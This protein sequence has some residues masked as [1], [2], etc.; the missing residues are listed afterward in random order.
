MNL[1]RVPLAARRT[2]R[3]AFVLSAVLIVSLG[4]GASS[5]P[6][7]SPGPGWAIR[8]VALPSS[9]STADGEAC[10]KEHMLCNSNSYLVTATNIGTKPSAGTVVVNDILPPGFVV[11]QVERARDIEA[12]ENLSCTET[13]EETS[14]QCTDPNPVAPGDTLAITIDVLVR[15]SATSVVNHAEV[16]G[17]E[18]A[19]AAT[20]ESTTVN[21]KAPSFGLQDFAVGVYGAGGAS[22]AQAGDHPGAL[23]TTIDYTTDFDAEGASFRF[24]AAQE[25]K[26]EIVDLPLGFV[27]DP[28]AAEQ[29]PESD[30]RSNHCPPDSQ[31]G[32]ADIDEEG[33][34][35][36][37]NIYNIVPEAGYPAEFAFE[38]DGAEVFLHARV[39][40][41]SSGYVLSISAP[42]VPRSSG[43]KVTGA[44]LTFFGDPAEQDGGSRSPQALYTNPSDCQAGPL[45]ARVEMDSW[46]DPQRWVTREATMYEASP[47]QGVS[48]CDMLQ[49]NPTIELK[50]E[51]TQADTP[52][53]Y[54]V[55]LKVPQTPNAWPAH[56][57]PDLRNTEVTLPEGV[58]VSPSAADGLVGCK[59]SGPEGIELGNN[60][61]LGHEVQEGEEPGADGLPHAAAGHC[62]KASQIGTV[63]VT[64]PLL[65]E[66]LEG[67]VYV[68]Q[69]K[70]G[71]EGQPACT[72]ASAAN[73]ELFGLYLE[74]AGSGVI[75]KLKG[76]VSV[77]PA[78]G[79]IT[80]RFDENPQLPFSELKLELNG[81]PRAPLANPQ[82]CGEARTTS[83]L[84]PWS[85]PESGPAATPFT[86]FDVSGC[87]SP[88]PFSPS[89]SAGTLTP[90]AGAFS[91][92]TLTFSR[93]DGQQDLSGLTVQTPPGLLGMLSQVQ[94]CPEPQA[95]QGTCGP[96]SQIGHTEVAAGAGSHPFWNPGAVYLTGPYKGQPFGLSIVTPATAGPF[97]LGNVIVRAAIH[98]DPETSALT[99]TSDP[100]PQIIDGVQLRI[101]T[102]NVSI[103]KPGFMFNPTN[104]DQQQIAGLIAGALP[105]GSPGSST[106]VSSLFA[107]AGCKNLP[108]KP[109]FSASTQG[110]TSK[111]DGASLVVK[112][113][114]KPGEANIH[115]VDLQLPLALP[116]RLTT[117]QK[118]CSEAQFASNPAG[119]PAGSVI[120]TATAHTPVLQAPLTGPAYLVSHGAAAFPDVEFVLQADERGGDVEIVLD[121]KTQIKKGITY[122]H[123]ETVPDAPINS[124]ETVLPEGPH[125]VLA[126]YLPASASYSLCGQSL[127]MPTTITGQNGARVI[128]T[129]K[130]AVTGC[131]NPAVRINKVEV[132]AN[133]VLVTLLTSQPGIVT[134][135]GR[136]LKTTRKTLGAGVHRLKVSLTKNGRIAR[137]LRRATGIKVSIKNPVGSSTKAVTRKL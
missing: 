119:C 88:M 60:D 30:L 47:T 24:V 100:L 106:A 9:F 113:A 27:G 73:G 13:P 135:S 58:S 39:L 137:K 82:S 51:Q 11:E 94:L 103:D 2:F 123:F 26:T 74:A 20:S 55:A 104:C 93:S 7:E 8:S 21:S 124:F 76:T 125:S 56:V 5:A 41:S 89:F 136:F 83:V 122:S 129:T 64:T 132:K 112:V 86:S 69:P 67:H 63:E 34:T 98:V 18:A 128:Q 133:A 37:E 48:G 32:V 66:K 40:P 6:A 52:S 50:P 53:G 59:E 96:Q 49:F 118:A 134:V 19:G 80:T 62:P 115:K 77:N 120:G 75:V 1:K 116:S 121:G 110:K 102:V 42:V 17:G 79:R 65:R 71:G 45:K 85:A 109:S 14:V 10:E 3:L 28:L 31:V 97:N 43:Y 44:T 29:C 111:A 68:A 57:T 81:G 99:V 127:A 95:S 16:Q 33:T 105:N 12:K 126:A 101:Q 90:A 25:P 107:A 22:N 131:S 108:F 91:P 84:E 4:A 117:L 46:V 72:E 114:Q 23:T 15:G 38:I 70:C 130:I 35:E 36:P 92:F 54:E 87:A 61:T 78:T